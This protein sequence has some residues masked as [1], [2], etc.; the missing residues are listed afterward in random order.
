MKL[1]EILVHEGLLTP[2]Q[3]ETALTA[4]RIFGGRLGTNLVEHGFVS[5]VDLAR[6][7]AR[8]LGV[9]MVDPNAL[10]SV[11]RRVLA[12]VPAD[13]ARKYAA[14]PFAHDEATDRVSVALADPNNLQKI[15]EI[16]FALGRR[17]ELHIA[18]EVML[19]FALEK[20]YGIE[21]PR[22]YVR[23]AG[24]S[25]VEMQL[26]QEER[27]RSKAAA[28]GIPPRVASRDALL[29]AVMDPSILNNG[30]V[31]DVPPPAG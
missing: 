15:D 6:V 20:Y 23:L 4:Q 22:R 25:D 16:Q 29:K 31:A 2:S 13:V 18:P 19:A 24:M 1:G 21:R 12:L 11:D 14:V 27:G 28:A 30:C 26:S 8:Q 5:E 3:L 17:I 9:R 7:L 10:A